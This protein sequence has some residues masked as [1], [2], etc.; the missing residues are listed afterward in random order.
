MLSSVFKRKDSRD[1]DNIDYQTIIEKDK[2]THEKIKVIEDIESIVKDIESARIKK[3]SLLEENGNFL[4]EEISKLEKKY[5]VTRNEIISKLES[6][7]IK[8]KPQ[9][10]MISVLNAR[11]K[12]NNEK[13]SQLKE[14]TPATTNKSGGFKTKR[15][16]RKNQTKCNFK[17]KRNISK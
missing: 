3:I 11:I 6:Q 13:L 17:C 5:K 12:L 14:S 2:K 9:E 7:P 16:K 4:K 8:L 1:S 15:R 10:D